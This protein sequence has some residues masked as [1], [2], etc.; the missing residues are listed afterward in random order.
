[1]VN[2]YRIRKTMKMKSRVVPYGLALP[3]EIIQSS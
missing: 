1:M 2:S 3:Q